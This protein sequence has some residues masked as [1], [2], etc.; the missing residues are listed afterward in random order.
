MSSDDKPPEEFDDFNEF[1]P[2]TVSREQYVQT[3]SGNKV[4]KN[5]LLCGSQNIELKGNSILHPGAVMR[6]DLAL[7]RCGISLL[8]KSSMQCI[9]LK[10]FISIGLKALA[11]LRFF[12]SQYRN[13]FTPGRYCIMQ[14]DCVLRPATKQHKPIYFPL[15]IGDFVYRGYWKESLLVSVPLWY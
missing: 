15:K 8:L 10:F 13:F 14:S 9:P 11:T 12:Q 2:Q 3:R 6:G 4:S 7:I 1:V 5:A